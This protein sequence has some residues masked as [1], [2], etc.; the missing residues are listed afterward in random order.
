[1]EGIKMA[2]KWF[3]DETEAADIGDAR[4]DECFT[5][6]LEA[7]AA[8]PTASLT[9][10]FRGRH[11]LKRAYRFFDN[12]KVTPGKILE[13]HFEKTAERCRS[14]QVALCVQDTT[15]LDFT[16][17]KQQVE[18]AG[19][20]AKAN[21]LGAFLHLVEAFTVNGTPLG[22]VWAKLWTRDFPD[23]DA[24]KLSKAEKREKW[25]D[26]PIEEKESVRW[27]E[28]FRETRKLA[29]ADPD[30]T[31]VS[32]CDSEADIYELLAEPRTPNMHFIIRGCQDRA[33]LDEHGE[34]LGVIRDALSS[35]PVLFTHEITVRGREPKVSCD[36]RSRRTARV[37]RRAITEVRA[38]AVTIKVPQ[39]RKNLVGSVTVNIVLV[40]E[41]NP[42]EGETPVEWILLTT[43][44]I[45]CVAEVKLVIEYYTVRWM[46][47]VYFRT[48]KTGCRVEERR[49][50]TLERML[51]CAAIYLIVAWRVLLVSRLGRKFPDLDCTV[52][53]DDS[54]WRA[55]WAVTHRGEPVPS[56]PPPL[57]VM[58]RLV[59]S[60]GGYVD[61]P[62]RP[63]PPGAET[64]WKG[65]QRMFDFAQAWEAFGPDARK[66]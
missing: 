17:P 63:D 12:P 8:A 2:G 50:E 10:T 19:P 66:S 58:I 18:G 43:L 55:V 61:R 22:A 41:I 4:L 5:D 35:Q 36:K 44:P 42:P 9:Q 62:S 45:S 32:L 51:A 13:P 15:E 53:F 21:R 38:A 65:H 6:I 39:G 7:L 59:A 20:L 29:S 16:K 54:E 48:L 52:L 24:P 60:L 26:T 47:E 37:S 1:M 64:L 57:S 3:T 27:L 25:R 46:I 40:R 11:E 31:Y 14:Q 23:P 28:G 34:T 33:V 30:T 56:T 49:F